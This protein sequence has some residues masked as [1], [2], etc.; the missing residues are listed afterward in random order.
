M[1]R[2][3]IQSTAFCRIN[4]VASTPQGLCIQVHLPILNHFLSDLER[5]IETL[6]AESN[7]I[8]ANSA[9]I[10]IVQ[11]HFN[12]SPPTFSMGRRFRTP[13]ASAS[14]PKPRLS[15]WEWAPLMTNTRGSKLLETSSCSQIDR[16][17]YSLHGQHVSESTIELR[18]L[19]CRVAWLSSFLLFSQFL[20]WT[21][22]SS[23]C[24]L[25]TSEKYSGGARTICDFCCSMPTKKS[26]LTFS[27]AYVAYQQYLP[28]R[29]CLAQATSLLRLSIEVSSLACLTANIGRLRNICP[30]RSVHYRSFHKPMHRM[31]CEC[32]LYCTVEV[33][34]A[35]RCMSW[36]RCTAAELAYTKP[37]RCV[38]R[39][40]AQSL[41]GSFFATANLRHNS[42]C[43]SYAWKHH[44]S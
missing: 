1:R 28:F 38:S 21:R 8:Q 12:S 35:L 13:T 7:L 32:T 11:R 40:C 41:R 27:C 34:I 15:D 5:G 20:A 6:A 4:L 25:K 10:L 2:I 37:R 31:Q 23:T 24:C 29:F 18:V 36:H 3:G 43:M 42:D 19:P 26:W 44:V 22:W 9:S 33:Q 14:E 17:L 39:P 16:I 30:R